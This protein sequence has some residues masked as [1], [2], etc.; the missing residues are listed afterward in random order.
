MGMVSLA[1]FVE[2]FS[3]AP[4]AGHEA[5]WF[6]NETHFATWMIDVGHHPKLA[7]MALGNI[8]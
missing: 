3:Q 8:D 1:S 4:A 2:L 6:L 7:H 5:C